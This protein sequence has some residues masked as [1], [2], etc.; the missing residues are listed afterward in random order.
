MRHCVPTPSG[1]APAAAALAALLSLAACAPAVAQTAEGPAEPAPFLEVS[2]SAEVSV[3]V[4]RAVVRFA[5]ETRAPSAAE[6]T[7][8][9]A[10]RMDAVL[11]ALRALDVEGTELETKG[12]SLQP[13]YARDDRSRSQRVIEAY[14]ALN[15]V[16][17][18]VSDTDAVG[19]ALDAGIE[20][21]ANRVAG[22]SFHASDTE[23][24]RLQAVG[25][26]VS[27]A[28]AEAAAMAAAL[29]VEL[30]P[31]LEVRGGGQESPGPRY[32]LRMESMAQ[33]ATTPVEPG[34]QTVRAS[35]TVKYRLGEGR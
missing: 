25:M 32:A 26:A 2:G 3:P 18:T 11:G 31:P 19:R 30:G 23:A 33:D 6:A 12:Y 4:D 29:G 24:A 10:A 22:I 15:H 9:N 20:A 17:L 14:V 28:R 16:H 27:K 7:R 34:E 21:G 8:S 13:V 35:V 1:P 5:V